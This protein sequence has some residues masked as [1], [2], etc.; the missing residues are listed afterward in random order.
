M[1]TAKPVD[2]QINNS[3]DSAFAP[4]V[5]FASANA[6]PRRGIADPRSLKRTLRTGF[7]TFQNGSIFR[8][9]RFG[10]GGGATQCDTGV[11]PV[12]VVTEFR[13][14]DFLI[15]PRRRHGRDARVTNNLSPARYGNGGRDVGP[16][17][18]RALVL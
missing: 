13:S 1:S 8:E 18:A 6:V 12:L 15:L 9:V 11:P 4:F 14:L 5:G 17:R 7:R 10:K 16:A 2:E 3:G